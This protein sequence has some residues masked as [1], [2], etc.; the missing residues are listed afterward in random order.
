M[1]FTMTIDLQAIANELGPKFAARAAEFDESD[2]FVR[3][4]YLAL[5][6]RGVFRAAIP[7]ELGGGGR[8]HSEMCRFLQLLATYC[9]STALACS[10][11]Q[12]LVAAQIWNHLHGKPA[13]AMLEKV[14][15][16]GLV[17]VSTGAND[18]L[19][20][21]GNAE[22]VDGG[23]KITAKKPFA[24]GG[25]G[26]DLLV[27]SAPYEDPQAG[28]QVLHF[29]VPLT[30]SGVKISDDWK[31]L[32][33][34]ATGSNTVSL[35][36]VFVP[37]ET[38]SLR[39]NRGEYHPFFNVIM[40]AALPLVCS[41]Y[42]G[43]AEAA[44]DRARKAAKKRLSDQTVPYLVGEMENEL[45]TARL[46][47]D[48]MVAIA[49]NLDFEPTAERSSAIAVRKTLAVNAVIQ[50]TEKALSIAGGGGYFRAAGIER[51][52]RDAHA[53]QFHPLQEKRQHLFTGRIALGLD[54]V[55]RT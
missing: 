19:E 24:S 53:G 28:W 9:S 2:T 23:F 8:P 52:L 4:N 38:V 49:N 17:L 18:W 27:T 30:A 31:T 12:H 40:G 13:R 43:V 16:N 22:K 46:A 39:R 14:A 11:H 25:P 33:M 21:N 3:D 20:S 5:K 42:L 48:S 45:A 7:E 26:G 47:V 15:K 54:P 50:T 44:A 37:E 41:V 10:M 29:A 35:E 32:G 6:E 34:R 51:L 1:R 36:G 55:E